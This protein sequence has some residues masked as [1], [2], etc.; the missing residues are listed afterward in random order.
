LSMKGS[1]NWR[2]SLA[3]FSRVLRRSFDQP[4]GTT[5]LG[6]RRSMLISPLMS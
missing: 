4:N 3:A 5:T 6:L 2:G 1:S